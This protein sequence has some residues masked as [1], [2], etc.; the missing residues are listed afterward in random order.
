MSV[1]RR[2]LLVAGLASPILA[3][4]RPVEAMASAVQRRLT[5][6][7]RPAPRG[8]SASRCAVCGGAGHAMLDVACPARRDLRR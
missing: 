6:L 3:T 7:G 1:T 5:P 2:R 8:T 4:L